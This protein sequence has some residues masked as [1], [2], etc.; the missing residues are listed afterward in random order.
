MRVLRK[1]ADGLT[2]ILANL[3]GVGMLLLFLMICV[4]VFL[5]YLVGSSIYGLSEITNYLFVYLTVLG[6]VNAIWYNDH[7]GV[8]F[9]THAG[10]TV[11]I[12]LRFFRM[13][14]MI[15]VQ[16]FI[17]FL[18]FLWISKVGSYLTPLLRFEQRWAQIAVPI[19]M[20]LGVLASV[21]CIILGYGSQNQKET[22]NL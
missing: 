18:S 7:V 3:Y 2:G 6:S 21:L 4:S 20:G 17:I 10:A 1:G 5:R 11:Q 8:D 15:V 16:A 19:G 13:L 14:V 12:I 9:F 22:Q